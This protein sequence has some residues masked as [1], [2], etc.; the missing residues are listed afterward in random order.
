[1]EEGEMVGSG[2]REEGGTP[3]CLSFP[4]F[5]AEETEAAGLKLT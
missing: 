4:H 1:M 3:V 2:Y 5:A